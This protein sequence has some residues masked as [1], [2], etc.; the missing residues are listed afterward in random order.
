MAINR[1]HQMITE[2]LRMGYKEKK[3][4]A[5][6]SNPRRSSPSPDPKASPNPSQPKPRQSSSNKTTYKIYGRRG[7]APVHTRFKGKVY[8]GPSDSRFK[9]KDRATVSLGTDGRL[10]VNDPKSGHTQH[11][12]SEAAERLIDDLVINELLRVE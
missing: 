2:K 1:Y 8:V 9:N 12:Y 3:A 11:W 4:Q 10:S 7:S 6:G 5:A